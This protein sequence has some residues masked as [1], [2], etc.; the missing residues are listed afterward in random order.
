MLLK[1][2]EGVQWDIIGLSEIQRTGQ[3]L[4]ELKNSHIF[5]YK[6]Q[7]DKEEHG[8]NKELAGTIEHFY[9]ISEWIEKLIEAAA[10]DYD[11]E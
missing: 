3:E 9:S 11:D 8:V 4:I 1:K 6:E 2:L 10:D 7:K 5:C